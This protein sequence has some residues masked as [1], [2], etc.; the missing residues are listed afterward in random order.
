MRQE[1]IPAS[2]V[3]GRMATE[4]GQKGKTAMP[5]HGPFQVDRSNFAHAG[6]PDGLSASTTRKP[7]HSGPVLMRRS[8]DVPAIS[9]ERIL[10]GLRGTNVTVAYQ[11]ADLV[12][13]W[14]ANPPAGFEAIAGKRDAEILPARPAAMLT[15]AKRVCLETGQGAHLIV[16][17][18]DDTQRWFD[19][20]LEADLVDRRDADPRIAGVIVVATD[21]TER[22]VREE[23]LR[24][25]LREV[26]HRARNLLAIVQSIASQTVRAASEPRRFLERFNERL[27]SLAHTLDL[28][29]LREWE[30]ATLHQLVSRQTKPFLPDGGSIEIGGVDPVLTPSAALHLGLALQ[31]LASNAVSHG[32]WRDRRGHVSARTSRQPDTRDL[33]FEWSEKGDG[34]GAPSPSGSFGSRTLMSVVPTALG[35][36]ASMVSQGEGFSYRLRIPPANFDG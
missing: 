3:I 19:V 29:T 5:V 11:D 25:L 27:Q 14:I 1:T 30:G 13:A 16:D 31:E 4:A 28:V 9:A 32:A 21:V 12:Y 17:I 22:V 10:S 8:K 20:W 7:A 23:R 15:E 6:R 33:L 36:E 24:V 2:E 34:R 35:G 26:S 18:D